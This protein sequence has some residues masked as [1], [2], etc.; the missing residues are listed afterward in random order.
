MCRIDVARVLSEEGA[1]GVNLAAVFNAYDTGRWL[2]CVGWNAIRVV[3]DFCFCQ[4]FKFILHWELNV[5]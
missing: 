2:L 5:H 4:V 3:S 1:R